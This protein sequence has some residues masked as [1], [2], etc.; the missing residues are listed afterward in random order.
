MWE[1]WRS[2]LADQDVE[3]IPIEQQK[4]LSAIQGYLELGMCRE[5]MRELK[6]L[7]VEFRGKAVVLELEIVVL[8]RDSRWKAASVAARRL[9]R[10]QPDLA[11]GYIHLAYCLHE[12]GD[13]NGA[14]DTLRKGPPALH[15]EG[16]YYYNLACYDAVLGDLDAARMNLARSIRIDKRF[17]DFAKGDTDL[18]ALHADLQ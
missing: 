7:P 8:I 14:R 16:T 15:K 18:S 1:N 11:A 10:T 3:T 4:T 2:Y 12:L 13:T 17:R 5:A 6:T 9:C